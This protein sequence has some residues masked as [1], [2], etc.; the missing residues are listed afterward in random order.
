MIAAPPWPW[1]TWLDCPG[2]SGRLAALAFPYGPAPSLS[3]APPPAPEALVDVEVEA[4]KS[5]ESGVAGSDDP[6]GGRAGLF[7]V[8][9]GIVLVD[10]LAVIWL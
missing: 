10:A 1:A 3:V 7:L 8:M 9:D 5:V 6:E 2:E 4:G